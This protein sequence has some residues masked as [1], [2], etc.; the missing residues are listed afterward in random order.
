M[1]NAYQLTGQN[2]IA[3]KFSARGIEQFKAIDPDTMEELPESFCIAS[4]EEIEEAM[5]ASIAAFRAYQNIEPTQRALFLEAIAQ[6]MLDLDDQLIQ[7]VMLEAALP[8]ARVVGERGR[9]VGQLRSF[10]ELIRAGDWVEPVIDLADPGR[11]PIPKSDIRK[12]LKPLG[13]VVVFGASNFP[14]AYSTS[15]GDTAA[16]LAAGNTVVVKAHPSHP[17]TTELV[18]A[19][20]A[21][22]AQSTGMPKGVFS[23]LQD[24]G[25]EVGTLLVSHPLTK[26]VGFTGSYTGG[27]A[28]QKL[29]MER[30]EPIPVFAEMGSV[31]PVLLLPAALEKKGKEIATQ[32]T[33]SITMGAGQFCTNPGLLIGLKGKPLDDFAQSLGEGLVGTSPQ[34][35]LNKG[36][37]ESYNQAVENITRKPGITAMPS[38]E[39]GQ[40]NQCAAQLSMVSGA[41]FLKDSE[42]L[43]EIFGPHSLLVCC[44][45]KE[46]LEAVVQSLNGQLTG[47]VIGE[48]D[49]LG[50]Y[51]SCIDLL[52]DKVGRIILN[53]VPTG[54][55][56]CAGMHHGGPFPATTDSR[57]TSVGPDAIRRFAR[58]VC[59]QDWPDHLLPAALQD[60][61]PLELNRYVDGKWSMEKISR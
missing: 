3:G 9:T 17:G 18:A 23:M 54:V 59:Y 47:T 50:E 43:H 33:G 8:E 61:N 51:T 37:A 16:A 58:P 48:N 13:P 29:A 35:M 28:L 39:A 52:K 12:C 36:I 57:F 30:T 53:G 40:G 22:A 2:L 60:H 10:A 21:R 49:E 34:N 1:E 31:N 41:D 26:A 5:Q 56:V 19:S 7:R 45:S 11:S 42:L 25:I 32:Y 44:D 14:L 24:N 20:I 38:L 4:K 27:M 46:E 6:E 55:E 15:G